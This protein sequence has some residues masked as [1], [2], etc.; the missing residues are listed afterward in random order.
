MKFASTGDLHLGFKQYGFPERLEDF[1]AAVEA[2]FSDAIQ[3]RVDGIILTGDSFQTPRPTDEDVRFLQQQV[4]RANDAG[5]RVYGIDGNHDYTD[6][7]WLSI[8]GILPLERWS[9]VDVDGTRLPAEQVNGD[10]RIFGLNHGSPAAIRSKLDEIEKSGAKF[11]ILVLHTEVVEM[12]AFASGGLTASEIVY[13]LRDSGCRLV[14][15][16]HIHDYAEAEFGGVRFIYAGSTEMWSRDEKP[17]KSFSVVEIEKTSMQTAYY[18]IRIRQQ[19]DVYLA[20]QEDL[21]KLLADIDVATGQGRSPVVLA[22]YDPEL[23]DFKKKLESLLTGKAIYLA[24]PQSRSVQ[25]S[26]DPLARL[27]KDA[28]DRKGAMRGMADVL[29]QVF[30]PESDESMLILKMLETPGD[31]ESIVLRYAKDKG[32][33]IK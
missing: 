29:Q 7:G 5:I 16:G 32:L 18:P 4:K 9:K 24:I 2:V 26:G 31:V 15:M 21:D 8:C 28:F 19:L 3:M 13:K 6:S 23:P 17:Q 20:T 10:C 12:C 33:S 14:L 30:G 25:Q 22:R 11:D 1:R 27:T